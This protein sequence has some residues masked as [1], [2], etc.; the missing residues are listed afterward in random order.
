MIGIEHMGI[1]KIQVRLVVKKAV[2]IVGLRLLV[3]LPVGTLGI[4]EDAACAAVFGIVVAPD[5]VVALNGTRRSMARGLE[6]GMLVRGVVDY[7]FGDYAQ[8]PAMGLIDEA[9]E[10]RHVTDGRMHVMVIG[11]IIAVIEPRG[12][13]EREEP[14]R[15]HTQLLQIVELG[16]Q[17]GKIADAI[18]VAVKEGLDVQLIYDG[19]LVPQWVFS[20]HSLMGDLVARC[21]RQSRIFDPFRLKPDLH[22]IRK[23]SAC[24]QM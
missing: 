20:F 13:I 9:V 6:P 18:T 2:P 12:R 10:V 8:P 11:D 4:G 7:Q 16:D 3:P 22:H 15:G 5:V 24:Q 17:A 1:V 19:V 14:E 23:G 21:V